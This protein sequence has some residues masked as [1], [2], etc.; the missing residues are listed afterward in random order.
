[1]DVVFGEVIESLPVA[2][3]LSFSITSMLYL[4]GSGPSYH[5]GRL[6][7]LPVGSYQRP[8]LVAKT[9]VLALILGCFGFAIYLN[10]SG[11]VIGS[12]YDNGA[13]LGILSAQSDGVLGT[14]EYGFAVN[15]LLSFSQL[16]TRF[17]VSTLDL[18]LT[19]GEMI[20]TSLRVA[21]AVPS[22]V[23]GIVSIQVLQ[24]IKRF[25]LRAS[26]LA[27]L[28]FGASPA[29]F[30]LV[31]DGFLTAWCAVSLVILA[32][33]LM[34][35]SILRREGFVLGVLACTLWFPLKPLALLI[36][37]SA[38]LNREGREQCVKQTLTLGLVPV[39]ISTI[40]NLLT[41]STLG[42]GSSIGDSSGGTF[43]SG[44]KELTQLP[45][46]IQSIDREYVLF[47]VIAL[48]A[49][50]TRSSTSTSLTA[51]PSPYS[52]T[53]GLAVY[54]FGL[55]FVFSRAEELSYALTKLGWMLC[56][57]VVF[58]TLLA[59]ASSD[60]TTTQY[61]VPLLLIVCLS[62]VGFPK[63]SEA[64]FVSFRNEQPKSSISAGPY[65]EQIEANA[66]EQ[67]VAGCVMVDGPLMRPVATPE[68][69]NVRLCTRL[70]SS[71]AG[72]SIVGLEDFNT[73]A[74]TTSQLVA[75]ATASKARMSRSLALFDRSGKFLK[76]TTLGEFLT[77]VVNF[78]EARADS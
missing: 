57:M 30:A 10:Q 5:P 15:L 4:I 16:V 13:W 77:G 20:F 47:W 12:G 42:G 24:K 75:R 14:Q 25:S 50:L 62:V 2:S 1:M 63:T 78:K 33:L 55:W 11:P 28:L 43:L 60:Q 37:L 76:F 66:P 48:V 52:W 58:S 18:E 73:G 45:G 29:I 54:A 19:R 34:S 67:R 17:F 61:V 74:L 72:Q 31:S 39:A 36:G 32:A 51:R 59:V 3:A 71:L 6:T 64:L 23:L 53:V 49:L 44:A 65:L 56:L 21:Y 27:L 38:L 35:T 68:A 7:E 9:V 69:Q 8:R 41:I 40:P 26:G 70:S 46:G 22:I